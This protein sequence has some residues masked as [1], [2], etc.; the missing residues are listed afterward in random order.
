MGR[1]AR[2]RAVIDFLVEAIS[3]HER[4]LTGVS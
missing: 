4:T 1:V 3:L 2:M